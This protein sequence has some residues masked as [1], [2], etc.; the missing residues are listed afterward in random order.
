LI[1]G[2]YF[3]RD[4]LLRLRRL[5]PAGAALPIAAMTASSHDG[6]VPADAVDRN[7]GTRWSAAG[8]GQWLRLDLGGARPVTSVSVAFCRGDQR[9]ARFDLPASANAVDWTT[10]AR[11]IASG[12]TLRPETYDVSDTAA[13]Y[14]RLVGHGAPGTTFTSVTE[15]AVH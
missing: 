13:R 4:A 7:L 8:D 9:A 1:Y 10:L 5:P 11:A 3:F 2:D 6:N 14:V 12:T 15:I